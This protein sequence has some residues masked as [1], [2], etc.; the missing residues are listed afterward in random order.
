[1][2]YNILYITIVPT[3]LGYTSFFVCNTPWLVEYM[4]TI[5]MWTYLQ[6]EYTTGVR[7]RDDDEVSGQGK[8]VENGA[9]GKVGKDG[10]QF[11]FS[12]DGEQDVVCK[13][14]GGAKLSLR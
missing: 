3:L 10:G 5:T 2:V 4:Q 6:I 8:V 9:Q 13:E 11:E 12:R 7:A 14:A 1:M